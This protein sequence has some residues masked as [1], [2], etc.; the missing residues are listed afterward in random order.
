MMLAI[1]EFEQLVIEALASLPAD[2]Q[3]HMENVVVLVKAWPSQA[4]LASA[5]VPPSHTLLGLYSGI[6]LTRRTSGYHLVPPDTITLYQG[7]IE[8][9]A[10]PDLNRIKGQVQRT[11]IH[12]IAHHFGISDDRLR[13]LDAY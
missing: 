11:V 3:I 1:N 10:G 7:P 13:E 9:A 6:P 8:Q 4:E 5:N 2:I 12:E